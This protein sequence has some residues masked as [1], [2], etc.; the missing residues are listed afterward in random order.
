MAKNMATV[1][2]TVPQVYLTAHFSTFGLTSI[3][4]FPTESPG[5]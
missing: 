4:D 5:L 3:I 1:R 2:L